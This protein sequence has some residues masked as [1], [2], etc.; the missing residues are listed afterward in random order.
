MKKII[1]AAAAFVMSAV[2]LTAKGKGSDSV[3]YGPRTGDFALS[4]EVTPAIDFIG[5]MFN[6]TENLN[7]QGFSGLSSSFF[8]GKTISAR[9]YFSDV[10]PL[11]V[12]FGVNNQSNKRYSYSYSEPNSL[13]TVRTSGTGELFVMVGFQQIIRPGQRIQPVL[14]L[15]CFY[16]HSNKDYEKIDSK[17]DQD[18]DSLSKSPSNTIGLVGNLGIEFYLSRKI[19]LSTCI[20]MGLYHGTSKTVIDNKDDSYSRTTSTDNS[21]IVGKLGGDI[22][23]NFYF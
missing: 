6:G 16:S 3:Y 14:G 9:Y 1:V 23:I 12:S 20:D 10:T 21:F 8:S 2:A 17:E 11:C 15:N 4:F 18:Y 13:E 19:S 22:S 7:F 5:N